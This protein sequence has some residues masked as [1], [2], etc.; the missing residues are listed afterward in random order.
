MIEALNTVPPSAGDSIEVAGWRRFWDS[1]N[2]AIALDVRLK[3]YDKADGKAVQTINHVHDKPLEMN[4][5]LKLNER[6]KIAMEK[7]E[8]RVGSAR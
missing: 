5:N 2:Q 6:F 3:L 1:V 8:Q 4:V 7:A